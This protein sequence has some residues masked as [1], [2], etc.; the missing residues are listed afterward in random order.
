MSADMGDEN[1]RCGHVPSAEV[2]GTQAKVVFL[3]VTLSEQIGAE[4]ADSVQ[5]CAADIK[6]KPDAHGD[7]DRAAAIHPSRHG[8]NARCLSKIRHV[9]ATALIGIVQD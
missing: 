3:A 8:V 6:A 2:A 4:Q 9:V 7:V 5:A 1:P